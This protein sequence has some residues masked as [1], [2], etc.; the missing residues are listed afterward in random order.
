MRYGLL[1]SLGLWFFLG[2][3]AAPLAGQVAPLRLKTP[4]PEASGRSQPNDAAGRDGRTADEVP[5][6]LQQ[7]DSPAGPGRGH[8]IIQFASIPDEPLRAELASRNITPIEYVPDNA[9][10]VALSGSVD[11][12]G[13]GI[14][15]AS[16]LP[17]ESKLSSL[18][19]S[20]PSDPASDAS[21]NPAADNPLR[22]MFGLRP[23]PAPRDAQRKSINPNWPYLIV[24][25]HPDVDLNQA[26]ALLLARNFVLRENPD[27]G[28]GRLMIQTPA[29][30]AQLEQLATEDAVAYIFPASEALASGAPAHPYLDTTTYYPGP[31][32]P[33]TASAGQY[34]ATYGD[35]WDGAGLNPATIGYVFGTLTPDLSTTTTETQL[36]AALDEWARVADLTWQQGSNQSATRTVAF[37]FYSGDHGDG[38][39]FDGPGG[40]LAHAFYPAPPNPETIAGDVHFD[41]AETWRVGSDI[42]LYSVA[43]HELGHSLGLGHSDDP[44][45]V[46][47]AYY[48]LHTSLQTDDINAILT[49]YAAAPDPGKNDPPPAVN[50]Q[51][52]S[53]SPNSGS[54]AS[55]TFT[56]TY[57]EVNGSQYIDTVAFLFSSSANSAGACSVVWDRAYD[58]VYLLWD[59][60]SG[61]NGKP[62]SSTSTLYNSQCSIGATSV[63]DN[64]SNLLV[65]VDVTFQPGF[66]GSKNVYMAAAGGSA[67]TGWALRGSYEVLAGG[68]PEARG[69]SPA[70]GSG[71]ATT[72]DFTIADNSGSS[73][74]GAA[75]ML[76][77]PQLAGANSCLVVWDRPTGT[78]SLL[79]D[80]MSGATTLTPGSGVVAENSQC[81]LYGA[82]S[83][84]TIGGSTIDISLSLYLK[85]SYAG[86]MNTYLLAV[87]SYG[88]SGWVDVGDWTV[89]GDVPTL[90]SLTPNSGSD[91]FPTFNVTFDAPVSTN[92]MTEESLLITTGEP[93]GTTGSCWV[94]YDRANVTI[95]LWDDAASTLNTKPLGSSAALQNSQ[96]AIGY[97]VMNTS[98]NTMTVSIQVLFKA[99]FSGSK[100]LYTEATA[101]GGSSGFALAGTWTVP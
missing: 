58:S 13:L 93:T 84:V 87:E 31:S 46:M 75:A 44:S 60:A 56:F 19:F 67:Y 66:S 42:D 78:L 50:P 85:P 95:G 12:T 101:G 2:C 77:A 82:S 17:A 48:S 89:P 90:N 41:E 88:N 29:D 57:S 76:I 94:V 92:T 99:A 3:T 83:S 96:C 35:G 16:P 5:E 100:N 36:T 11:A 43:L 21:S 47:Y 91:V 24:E 34:I 20:N 74:L 72:M 59:N 70:T 51:L 53:A 81:I 25:F 27:L 14:L 69:V 6:P 62:T 1:T 54:G 61:S 32:Q 68:L 73:F 86:Q 40:V 4:L 55:G 79:Y 37:N 39:P 10:L 15:Y 7:L 97:A 22:R 63:T 23:A 71:Y 30:P 49:L 9:L 8:L 98:G 45:A 64:G 52:V 33:Q 28:P 26:R 80:N 18:I 38:F 65:T